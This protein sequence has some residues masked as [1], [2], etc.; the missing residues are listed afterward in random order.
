M[1]QFSFNRFLNVARWDLTINRNFYIQMFLVMLGCLSMP[2]LFHYLSH[3]LDHGL[4]QCN[5]FSVQQ[6]MAR[7]STIA[8]VIAFLANCIIVTMYGFT[9]HNLRNRQGRIAELTLPASNLERFLWHV[10]VIVIGTQIMFALSVMLVDVFNIILARVVCGYS[11]SFDISRR[12]FTT[13]YDEIPQN[14]LYDGEPLPLSL[15]LMGPVISFIGTSTFALVNAYKYRM[16]IAYTIL[17]HIVGWVLLVIAFGVVFST[18]NVGS[19][20][21]IIEKIGGDAMSYIV[22]AMLLAILA[23]IWWLTYRLYCRAQFTS[24]R[25]R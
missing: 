14:L 12:V 5:T 18:F 10:L 17:Y 13:I 22:L 15:Y 21:A 24:P 2:I 8:F 19:L 16:N 25:N 3:F 20:Y 7:N 9:F 23:F 4:G 6:A 1:T 11:E